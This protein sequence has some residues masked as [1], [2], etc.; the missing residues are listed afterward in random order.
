MKVPIITLQYCHN[1]D[2]KGQKYSHIW[3]IFALFKLLWKAFEEISKY[4]INI[5]YQDETIHSIIPIIIKVRLKFL[6]NGIKTHINQL[7]LCYPKKNGDESAN[8]RWWKHFHISSLTVWV[9]W[10]MV[11]GLGLKRLTERMQAPPSW[12]FRTIQTDWTLAN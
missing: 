11:T 4:R 9:Q 2:I 7:T 12:Q 5:I 8:W 10:A 3:F 1:I 6:K